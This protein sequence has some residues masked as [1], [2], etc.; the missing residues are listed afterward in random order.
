MFP[1]APLYCT[2][3]EHRHRFLSVHVDGARG[4][5][6][7]NIYN[8]TKLRNEMKSLQRY[9]GVFMPIFGDWWLWWAWQWD[10]TMS[11][12]DCERFAREHIS[13]CTVTSRLLGWFPVYWSKLSELGCL[14]HDIVLSSWTQRDVGPHN[15]ATYSLIRLFRICVHAYS[16]LL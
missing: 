2:T 1:Q 10:W 4:K 12:L 9:F 16:I 7:A 11:D 6:F 5:V 3:V 15:H 8:G 14:Y 13:Q